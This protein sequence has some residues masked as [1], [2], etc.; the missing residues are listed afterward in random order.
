[1]LVKSIVYQI[2]RDGEWLQGY[3]VGEY[4][5]SDKSI[6]LTEDFKAYEGDIWDYR[7]DYRINIS[8]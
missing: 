2:V 6:I 8:F 1:M 5:G 3:Y 4:Y 7:A